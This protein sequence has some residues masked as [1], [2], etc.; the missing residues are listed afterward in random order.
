MMAHVWNEIEHDIG[1]KPVGGGPGPAEQGLLQAL[2]H[3]TQSGDKIIEQILDANARR[4][5][6]LQGDFVDVYDFVAR[7][8][9][10]FVGIRIEDNSGQ[11]FDELRTLEL[12]S[13]QALALAIGKAYP[14]IKAAEMKIADFN[15]YLTKV[16]RT[17]FTLD[18]DS[19][20]I[21]LV[22]L[23]DEFADTIVENHPSGRG[24]GRP[25]RIRSLADRYK[26]WQTKKKEGV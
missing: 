17:E 24:L 14:G 3:V 7:L 10:D 22:Q 21:I 15:K 20:D 9:Q 12:T 25:P 26:E 13:K 8:R 11:L 18:R 1:Y 2:G 16:R 19:S 4:L 5:R 6:D 23:L